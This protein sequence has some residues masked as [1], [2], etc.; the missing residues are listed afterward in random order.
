LAVTKSVVATTGIG[1]EYKYFIT[2][3]WVGEKCDAKC[4]LKMFR[5]RGWNFLC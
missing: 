4:L 5:G 3:L 2:W 1:V